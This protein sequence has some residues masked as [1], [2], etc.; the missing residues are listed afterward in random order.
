MSYLLALAASM[1]VPTSAATLTGIT[2]GASGARIALDG[3]A[4]YRAFRLSSPDRFVV[5]LRGTSLGVAERS[6]PGAGPVKGV[7]VGPFSGAP[8]MTRV[9]F[10]LTT[11][12]EAE[13][14]EAP[15]A[16]L[17]EFRGPVLPPAETPEPTPAPEPASSAPADFKDALAPL[18]MPGLTRM[19][20]PAL[21]VPAL[22]GDARL[23]SVEASPERVD[24]ALSGPFEPTLFLLPSPPRL[25]INLPGVMAPVFPSARPAPGGTVLAARS[26]GR[27]RNARVVI[28]LAR[29]AP[30]SVQT[31]DGRLSVLFEAAGEEPAL[32]RTREYKGWIVD[33]SGRPLDGVFLVRFSLPE[34]G[35]LEGSRWEQSS[36][37]DARGGRF[38][39]V[40]GREDPIPA[41][42][43]R[44]GVPLDAAAPPGVAW[45]VVPR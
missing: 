10:D 42:A 41:G 15:G 14:R 26:A 27:G 45:R 38:T 36:Y 23:L 25:V 40:L 24:M 9:V 11:A 19:P 2:V 33:G 18:A 30:Y 6:W 5:D 32:S 12:L 1:A 17:V 29:T 13:T 44:P 3:P 43:L 22:A 37:V 7:R 20:P 28:D 4:E 8:G 39:A 35:V 34:E 21:N 31:A 16:V